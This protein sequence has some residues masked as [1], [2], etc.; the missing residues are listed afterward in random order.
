MSK[1]HSKV[2]IADGQDDRV[3]SINHGDHKHPAA[4]ESSPAKKQRLS[5]SHRRSSA[6]A[7]VFV[8][9]PPPLVADQGKRL[10]LLIWMVAV[11][12]PWILQVRSYVQLMLPHKISQDLTPQSAAV[13]A[14]K[15]TQNLTEICPVA[16][17]QIAG[18]WWNAYPTH[19][20]TA[21]DDSHGFIGRI[22]HFVIPQYNIHGAY[23]IDHVE[24][25]SASSQKALPASCGS[26]DHQFAIDYYFYHGSIGYYSFYEEGEGAFCADDDTAYVTVAKL[27]SHDVNGKFLAEDVPAAGGS[28]YR[29]SYYYGIFGVCWIG[30]RAL[31]LRRSFITC[32]RFARRC[33]EMREPIAMRHAV[34]FVQESARLSAHGARN[35]HRVALLY[36][37]VEG[38]MGD[39]FLLI[40]KDGPLAKVQYISLG[41]NLSSVLSILFEMVESTHWLGRFAQIVKRLL[42]NYET[43]MVGELLC[44]ALMQAFLTA[45]NRSDLRDSYTAAEA[46]SYYIWSLVGHGVIV[47]GLASF[48]LTV[49]TLGALA[50]MQGKFGSV[51]L[52]A[53]CCCVDTAVGVRVKQIQ[54]TGYV[55]SSATG[56]LYYSPETLKSIGMLKLE[57]DEED[58]GGEYLVLHRLHWVATPRDDLLTIAKLSG[59]HAEFCADDHRGRRGVLSVCERSLGGVDHDENHENNTLDVEGG[60][61]VAI[62]VEEMHEDTARLLA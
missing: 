39:L 19:Y 11:F 51:R 42:F 40:A 20:Y 27:G 49:R 14:T 13:A 4:V 18:A 30:Y 45:L 44:A 37:L 50:F 5:L 35:Y 28:E 17:L 22:C 61:E 48:I 12:S 55:R 8:P 23:H 47:L 16:G 2:Y 46:V 6:G 21:H 53:S 60:Q 34:V 54:L 26:S 56:G 36:L 9:S 10:L 62:S 59:S 31:V 29:Q 57:A 1:K 43:A 32:F 38:L 25:A 33:N 58:G 7:A 3:A 52:I 41:Y 15:D 24:E